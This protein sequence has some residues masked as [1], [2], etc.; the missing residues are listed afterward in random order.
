MARSRNKTPIGGHTKSESEKLWKSKQNRKLRRKVNVLLNKTQ[1]TV[2]LDVR[3][4]SNIWAGPK[5]GKSYWKN[6]PKE[7]LRK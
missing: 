2:Q 5:D 3:D 4:V 1:D 6:A 7:W